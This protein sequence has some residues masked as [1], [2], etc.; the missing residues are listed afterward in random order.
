[1]SP[2]VTAVDAV[3]VG[4]GIVGT[5]TAYHLTKMGAKVALLE[6]GGDC[7]RDIGGV[8]RADPDSGPAPGPR[9]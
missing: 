4:G 9:A 3:V 1:M 6:T 7:V 2:G 5:S 8:R